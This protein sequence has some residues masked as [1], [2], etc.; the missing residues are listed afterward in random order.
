MAAALWRPVPRVLSWHPLAQMMAAGIGF[1]MVGSDGGAIQRLSVSGV[2]VA[3]ATAFL[4]DDPA[5]ET[6]AAS[7]TPLSAR[8]AQRVAIV[9]MVVAS[10]WTVAVT[11][12]AT[13][14]GGFPLR[15]R[16]LEL[17]VLV[18]VALAV[19]AAAATTGDRTGGGI[20]GAACSTAC[21]ASTL[22]PPRWWLPFPPDPTAAGAALRWVAVLV[23]AI[24]LL[25]WTSRDPARPHAGLDLWRRR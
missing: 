20:A 12:A 21:F 13:R 8:R 2:G 9:A 5:S 7:P 6:L 10:W 22:L 17:G 4:L 25:A 15:G 18:T 14:A 3:A 19:S 16:A 23:C 11:V 1:V 24:A